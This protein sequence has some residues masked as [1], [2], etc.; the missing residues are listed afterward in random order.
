[1]NAELTDD[2]RILF[3]AHNG[4]QLKD[5]PASYFHWLWINGRKRD[6]GTGGLG[7]YIRSRLPAKKE[8]PDGIWD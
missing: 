5:V 3:G 4:K 6:H 2:D 1:M 8:F 7:N